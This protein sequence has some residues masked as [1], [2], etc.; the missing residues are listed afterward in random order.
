MRDGSFDQ[1]SSTSTFVYIVGTEFGEPALYD[2]EVGESWRGGGRVVLV[3]NGNEAGWGGLH[4][5]VHN[6]YLSVHWSESYVEQDITNLVP[7][8]SYTVSFLVANRPNWP[9]T[10]LRASV[11]DV[12][13]LEERPSNVAFTKYNACFQAGDTVARLK[14]ENMASS[15]NSEEASIFLA[16]V[17]V[18][19]GALNPSECAGM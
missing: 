15:S 16:D 7:G 17:N 8:S 4:P 14:F 10:T 1:I 19:Q 9:S 12:L 6:Y 18:D 3:R 11:D 13:L 5:G 2:T